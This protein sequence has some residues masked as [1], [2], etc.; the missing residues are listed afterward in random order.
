MRTPAPSVWVISDGRRGIENQA[1]GLAEAMGRINPISI[2]RKIIGSDPSFAALPPW[3]QLMRRRTPVKYGLAAPFPDIAIGCGRQ[4][5]APLRA[6]KA[7][8]PDTYI[9]YVQDPRSSYQHFDLI[10]APEHDGLKRANVV[11]MIGAPNR[12]TDEKLE[13]AKT[14]FSDRLSQ[15]TGPTAAFLIGG[16]SKYMTLD[17]AS[18]K[19]HILTAQ[20]LLSEGYALFITLS[21]RTHKM[22]QTA[23]TTLANENSDKIWFYDPQLHDNPNPY[24]AF[25][26]VADRI[27]VTQESTNMLTEACYT[28][29]PVHRLSMSGKVG[30]FEKLYDKLGGLSPPLDIKALSGSLKD[31][32][33]GSQIYTPLRETDHIANIVWDKFASA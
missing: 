6:I 5:I 14:E 2:K 25:L 30:K 18:I 15:Y 4:A 22:A 8:H 32:P 33:T 12:I 21:R 17:S 20:T 3:L 9:I 24:F 1:L 27:F 26:A 11:S 23:W 28:G 7:A 19:S 16:E 10:I 13:A 29:R 31:D